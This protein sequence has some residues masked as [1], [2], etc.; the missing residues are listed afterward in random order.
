MS[1]P[2]LNAHTRAT[3]VKPAVKETATTTQI[4]N[5]IMPYYPKACVC[6][7]GFLDNSDQYWKVNYHWDLLVSKIDQFLLLAGVPENLKSC[8]R[9]IRGA[10]MTNAPNPISGYRNDQMVGFTKDTSPPERVQAR[11][12]ILK[13]SKKDFEAVLVKAK[14]VNQNTKLNP[15]SSEKAW[16]LSVAPVAAPGDSK[17][18]SGYALDIAGN[19]AETTTISKALGATLVFNEASH[20]HVEWKNGVKVAP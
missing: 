11:H 4:I 2:K 12:G 14:V 13:Q 15:P 5:A 20:V 1:L 7:A 19:N 9:A 16:W 18:G 6:I 10:L 3:F 17:H 8:G